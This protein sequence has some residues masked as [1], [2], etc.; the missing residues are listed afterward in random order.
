[1]G[2]HPDGGYPLA[3]GR[4]NVTARA[5]LAQLRALANELGV[6]GAYETVDGVHHV[7]PVDTILA[8]TRAMGVGVATVADAS[9]AYREL[10]ESR[11]RRRLDPV[12]VGRP[13]EPIDLDPG[14][15]GSLHVETETGEHRVHRVADGPQRIGPLP[16]G[17]HRIRFEPR[18]GG[19][20]QTAT[21]IV[22][23]PTA[24]RPGPGDAR[25]WGVFAPVYA[26]HDEDT[27]A[28]A[29]LRELSRLADI[30][31]DH[32]GRIVGTLPLLATFLGAGD[33]PYDP[34]PYAPVSRRFWNELYLDLAALP[35]IDPDDLAAL[36]DTRSVEPS[37]GLV[38]PRAAAAAR[39]PLLEAAA[40]RIDA[41]DTGRRRTL[42]G[43]LASDPQVSD[44]ARFRAGLEGSGDAGVRYHE[45]VQWAAGE[46]I[47]AFAERLSGRGGALYL[48]LPVGTNAAGFDVA[49][50]PTSFV[51]GM[52]VGAPPDAFFAEGQN[53]GFPPLSPQGLR[54]TGFGMLR[55]TLEHHLRVARVLRIDH[56]MGLHR[57]FWIPAGE[58]P[59]AGTYV[60][61]PSDEI[62]A[63]L[64]VLSHRYGSMVI[65]E[66]L[67]TVPK[68][69]NEA[70]QANGIDRMRVFELDV[71][72]DPD[73]PLVRP[74]AETLSS[75][76]THDTPTFAAFWRGTDIDT[77]VEVGHAGVAVAVEEREQRARLRT[78]IAHALLDLHLLQPDDLALDLAAP[79]TERSVLRAVLDFTAASDAD[80]VLVTLE[81]LWGETRA[82]NIPGTGPEVP[83]WRRRAARSL[84]DIESDTD[85]RGH[86][87]AVDRQRRA[88]PGGATTERVG[89]ESR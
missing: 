60:S 44:Y 16:V 29:G 8:A 1:V 81:D 5:E 6:A 89:T 20:T 47:R 76:N 67:G 11:S 57:L 22:A 88:E 2:P 79:T 86:L 10:M 72:E 19:A 56:V 65:G 39:R 43:F 25:R 45:Y 30:T 78:T 77:R 46:Q 51:T 32:G 35:E 48:D 58:S 59:T 15:A 40:I 64:A 70:L 21:L 17:L 61:Y 52:S 31:L 26:L 50:D 37:G 73:A 85:V 42:R 80:V 27:G 14:S 36:S 71:Y 7:T 53:W 9:W 62:Y 74:E 23:P 66:N 55:A 83:N 24:F 13:G 68:Q 34:S 12:I 82:Q 63:L 3:D 18:R 87:D 49:S 84:D 28:V 41:Q 54:A 75:L 33:E 38:D 4:L 69:V